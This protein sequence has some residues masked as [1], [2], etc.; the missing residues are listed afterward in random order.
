[1][2]CPECVKQDK[3]SQVYPGIS[4]TTCMGWQTY[5]DE[6]GMFHSHDPNWTTTGYACSEGHEW[7]ESKQHP[8][9]N[10]LWGR[11]GDDDDKK[12]QG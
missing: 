3:K 12:R 6:D 8:C 4:T 11:E 1:M 10:C 7:T 2:K 9:P 5:Y